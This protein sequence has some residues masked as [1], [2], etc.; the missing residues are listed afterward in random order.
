[1]TSR[2]CARMISRRGSSTSNLHLFA[3][4][5]LDT[6]G[7][8]YSIRIYTYILVWDTEGGSYSPKR[9]A[10]R[11][12]FNSSARRSKVT[13]SRALAF[14]FVEIQIQISLVGP[15]YSWAIN[16]HFPHPNYD[17][18]ARN[19]VEC[20]IMDPSDRVWRCV[21]IHQRLR[22]SPPVHCT[23]FILANPGD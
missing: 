7:G 16:L 6:E 19:H 4:S 21:K 22:K 5:G 3:S 13:D 15:T 14:V 20:D 2:F 8:L 23:G 9:G 1:M 10:R 17:S 12:F 18:S 11:T